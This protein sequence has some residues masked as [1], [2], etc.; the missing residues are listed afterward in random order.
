MSPST[1]AKLRPLALPGVDPTVVVVEETASVAKLPR[2][3][4]LESE[5]T[6]WI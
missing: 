5:P 1:L 6:F 4:T 3:E 2:P